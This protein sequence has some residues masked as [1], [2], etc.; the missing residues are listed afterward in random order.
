MKA[1]TRMTS[2]ALFLSIFT[3]ACGTETP[4][5]MVNLASSLEGEWLKKCHANEGLSATEKITVQGN[6]L[7][8]TLTM[9]SDEKCS[10]GGE[11]MTL[12]LVA[13]IKVGDRSDSDKKLKELDIFDK[14]K[15]IRM[16]NAQMTAQL[17]NANYY[18]HKDW[19]V[20]V[21]KDLTN[22][23]QQGRESP[24]KSSYTMFQAE[25]SRLCI[26]SSNETHTGVSEENR[27]RTIQDESDCFEKS[28]KS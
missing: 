12:R 3:A 25:E 5:N 23:T 28:V 22:L 15:F 1:L 9:Y 6:R 26:G 27:I 4:N 7:E 8:R 10:L 13:K 11:V 20:G 21:E 18:G 24:E 2:L 17:N 14:S 16:Q 19:S